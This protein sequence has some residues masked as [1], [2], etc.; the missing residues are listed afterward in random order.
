[1]LI[2]VGTFIVVGI[3]LGGIGLLL[4]AIAGV[5]VGDAAV[6]A[7]CAVPWGIVSF[8]LALSLAT[9]ISRCL[10]I[11]PEYQRVVVLKMGEFAGVRG[12][13]RFW[14]IPYPPYYQ[15]AA[16]TL[17]MRLQTQVI[18]AAE[19]LTK[20]NVPVGCEAVI[21]WR[22][23]DPR[24]A[25]LKVQ[26]H[27][28]AVYLAANSA[29]KDTVGTLELSELLSK[30]DLVAQNLEQIIDKAASKFGVDVSSVEITDV[31]VP[32]D[33]IQELS[34]LAQ[35]ERSAQA[36]IAEAKAELEVAKQFQDAANSMGPKAMEIYRLNVLERIGREE[37][38]QI[39]V[40]GLGGD[41]TMGRQIAIGA[42]GAKAAVS[43]RPSKPATGEMTGGE[44]EP[45]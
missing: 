18:K 27:A 31:R 5:V 24:I 32:N 4:S 21:F 41:P 19:T 2:W 25:A 30:R 6:G 34:V 22:V 36:K 33:L 11:I 7:V 26:N 17:D 40:Y 42:A 37:G 45:S 16:M 44:S 29:L 8:I 15:S 13:G 14:V 10:Y 28:E 12:P 3:L 20:D 38:S 9:M 39:V 35:S 1:M 23:E 43:R